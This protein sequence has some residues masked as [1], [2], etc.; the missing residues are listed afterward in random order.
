MLRLR[1]F[2]GLSLDG[3]DGPV[4]GR[5]TQRRRLVLLAILAVAR[6][7]PASRDKI[8]ALLWPEADTERARH[9]LA[10]SVYVLR[11]ELGGDAI[12]AAGDT[13]AL[14]AER[15]TSDVAQFE[16]AI[17]AGQYEH[18]VGIYAMSGAFLDGVH[19]SDAGDLERWIDGMRDRMDTRYRETLETLAK[20]STSQGNHAAAVAWWRKL[21]GADRLSSRVALG[22]M[23]ALVAAG[24]RAGA[25]EFARAH[26][27][28]TRA[29]LE[30]APDPAVVH[31][32]DA[33]RASPVDGVRPGD[34]PLSDPS[35]GPE[36]RH[37]SEPATPLVITRR[38]GT[39]ARTFWIAP[40]VFVV[41]VAAYVT[42]HGQP[43]RAATTSV[44]GSSDETDPSIAVLPLVNV[45]ADPKNESLVDGMT[46]ELTTALGKIDRLRVRA[47]TSA[48]AFKGHRTDV[49]RIADSLQVSNVLEGGLQLV[50]DRFRLNVRLVDAADASTR[51]SETYERRLEDVL[52]VE[53]EIGRAVANAL[54]VRLLKGGEIAHRLRHTTSD[55]V[56]NDS[57][58]RG[59]DQQLY[60]SDS[61][62]RIAIEHFTRAIDL[63][64]RFAA[65]YA[66]L[67]Q[68]YVTRAR[69]GG[70]PELPTRVLLQRAEAAAVQAVQL[71]D[72]LADAHS[73]LAY[74]DL[75]RRD[76]PAAAAQV[77]RALSLDPNDQ[78]ARSLLAILY[79]WAGRYDEAL[80]EARRALDVD[81]LSPSSRVELARALFY[82]GRD[83]EALAELEPLRRLRPPIRRVPQLAG[84]IYGN[85]NMWARAITELRAQTRP[86][87]EWE[88][89]LARAIGASGDRSGAMR[90]LEDLLPRW[91]AGTASAFSVASL[92]VG[93]G[94]YDSAFVWLD[95]SVDD[96]SLLVQVM[97]PTF[98]QLRDDRRFARLRQRIGLKHLAL[99]AATT[100]ASRR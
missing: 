80:T 52:A 34:R 38:R 36:P 94:E 87:F 27:A 17:E 10:D 70:T 79:H 44:A 71:D 47:S 73:N 35:R 4:A 69:A 8:I 92:Y 56:A 54:R 93:L 49:R 46:E 57:Y 82:A 89:C 51:W 66:G 25:L 64:P 40:L 81:R 6:E 39:T 12:V 68:A 30:S 83:S 55:P 21:A 65:A 43:S 11:D 41:A 37:A 7:R 48:F 9:A 53:D 85:K 86:G 42:M 1:L 29:E 84:A 100:T 13:L 77:S 88:A 95:R 18:A 33:L 31:F 62:A 45:S 63:D 2:G 91:R 78:L 26:E 5:A 58:L 90:M 50:G 14:N 72:S 76:F 97:D 20:A 61:G 67:A 15:I 23:R 74:V 22:L 3:P 99:P 32:A 24:D 60:R 59:R 28:I 16:D 19:V 75:E 98:K 96:H